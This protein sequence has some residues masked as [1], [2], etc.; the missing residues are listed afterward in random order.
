MENSGKQ[1]LG[2]IMMEVIWWLITAIVV[3]MAAQPLWTSFVQYSFVYELIMFGVI[4][5]TYTRYLF[6]MKYTFL[7]KAQIIKFVFIFLSLPLAFYLIQV[8]FNYQ[9]FLEK[10]NDGM[11]E[12]QEYFR[13]GISFQEHAD[14]LTYLSKVYTFFGMS[15]IIAVVF[16]PFRLL[17]SYWRVYNK[18]GS[19]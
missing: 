2:K 13:K 15:A 14:T 18:T 19:V 9:D 3:I 5:I 11:L 7:A 10:Q 17:V 16:S 1:R 4:F 12:F 8:F 6:F